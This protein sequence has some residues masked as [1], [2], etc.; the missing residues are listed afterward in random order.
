MVNEALTSGVIRI[1]AFT[2][3]EMAEVE[4]DDVRAPPALKCIEAK[5]SCVEVKTFQLR[6]ATDVCATADH[7]EILI[8]RVNPCR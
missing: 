3:A 2:C 8:K 5:I 1:I 7:Q 4:V 6:R